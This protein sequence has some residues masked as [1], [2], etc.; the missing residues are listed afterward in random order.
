MRFKTKIVFFITFLFL[1]Y[2]LNTI[3]AHSA[4]KK[5]GTI[6]V[7]IDTDLV[8]T[9]PHVRVGF[10]NTVVMC[11]VFERLV[12]YGDKLELIPVLA[13]K[14]EVSPDLKTYTFFLRKGKLFHNGR[15]MVADDVKYSIERVMD[16][17]TGNPDRD[18]FKIDSIEVIDKYKVQFNMK[19]PDSTLLSALAAIKPL[20]GI[21]PREEVE[22]QGGVMSHPVGTGPYKFV[23][24]KPDRYILLERFDAYKPQPGPMNG[25]GGERIA[26]IDKIM[27]IPIPEESVRTMAFLNKEIDAIKSVPLKD[28]DKYKEEYNQKGI[29]LV[30]APGFSWTQLWFGCDKQITKDINFRRAC[31]YAVDIDLVSNASTR[32]HCDVNASL[33]PTA[34]QYHTD[35]HKKWYEKNITKAKELLKKSE[36]KGEEIP[37]LCT[38]KY[39]QVYQN[40]ITLQSE[41][42]EAGIKTKLEVLDWPT[43]LERYFKG[44]FQMMSYIMAPRPDPVEIYN[45][46]THNGFDAQ[47]P[48]VAE[49]RTKASQTLDVETRTKLFEQIHELIIEGVPC[50]NLNNYRYYNAH[51]D[52]VKDYKMAPTNIPCLWG[53]WL[54]K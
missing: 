40:A 34:N 39:D 26:Y 30:S 6:K 11:N 23:E 48:K 47:Y 37:L 43:L 33:I 17:K 7:Q 27:Y 22:K 31:A 53:V 29:K 44:D 5:G 32:G 21:V 54:D 50:I 1:F 20:I 28:V 51:W 4:P 12:G 35:I 19:A 15:E 25:Y 8:S 2:S 45:Q 38:R 18:K 9:D 42:A 49:L 3:S 16:P 24:W 10:I 36:Y 13:E 46:L 52:Y 14:W 41:L